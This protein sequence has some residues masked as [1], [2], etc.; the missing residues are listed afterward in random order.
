MLDLTRLNI[1]PHLTVWLD[2]EEVVVQVKNYGDCIPADELPYIYDMFYTGDQART[3]REGSTGL[4][5]SIAKNI[6]TQ[7]EGTITVQS[8]LIRTLFEVRIPQQEFSQA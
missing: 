7:H 2:G 3:H 4:G 5:L 8:C 1:S 6:V